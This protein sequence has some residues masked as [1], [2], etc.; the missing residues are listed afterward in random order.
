MNEAQ[1]IV[2]ERLRP[3]IE[4]LDPL[5]E[6]TLRAIVEEIRDELIADF[7]HYGLDDGMVLFVAHGPEESVA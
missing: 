7:E 5:H 4:N 3:Y 6:G 2:Q 1:T